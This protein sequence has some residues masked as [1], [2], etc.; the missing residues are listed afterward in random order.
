MIPTQVNIQVD[1]QAV[2]QHIEKHL[3]NAIQSQ[4]WFL[5]AERISQLTS[6]SKRYL[7]QEVFCDARMRAIEIKKQRK[8]WWPAKQAFEVISEIV[9]EW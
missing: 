5:D 6:M 2:Q 1:A 8:R 3:E 4:L 7:E 9:S